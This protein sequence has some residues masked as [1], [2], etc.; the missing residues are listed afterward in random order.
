[1]EFVASNVRPNPSFEARP[2]GRP[3]GPGRW[4]AYIV[5]GPGLAS[6]RWSHLNSNVR[7]HP[8]LRLEVQRPEHHLE[9]HYGNTVFT[10]VGRRTLGN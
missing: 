4:Y 7:P 9:L 10:S 2:N 6:C 8:T 3:P 1:M 5:T